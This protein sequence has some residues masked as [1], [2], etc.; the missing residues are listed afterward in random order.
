MLE[1]GFPD[2]EAPTARLP[3]VLPSFVAGDTPRACDPESHVRRQ[4]VF[5]RPSASSEQ[6]RG[7]TFVSRPLGIISL[8]AGSLFLSLMF[9]FPAVLGTKCDATDRTGVAKCKANALRALLSSLQHLQ[10]GLRG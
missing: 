9:V 10:P 4:A 1:S 8:P 2:N 6:A 5:P 7:F 3:H